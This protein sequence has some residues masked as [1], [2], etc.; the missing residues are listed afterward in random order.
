MMITY[1]SS[2]AMLM[3]WQTPPPV[4]NSPADTGPADE[5]EI[6]FRRQQH[7][8]RQRALDW[9]A[10]GGYAGQ[11]QRRAIK[12]MDYP[13]GAQK[14]K[15]KA[16]GRGGRAMGVGKGKGGKSAKGRRLGCL[17]HASSLSIVVKRSDSGN[18][19][20]GDC[21]PARCE[22]CNQGERFC[23]THPIPRHMG[24]EEGGKP[25]HFELGKR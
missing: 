11:Q 23:P 17:R 9:Q 14:G 18:Q 1:H 22:H 20:P 19:D 21:D 15:G 16:K 3:Q 6:H 13:D 4:S 10:A 2:A 12:G 25:P 24:R 7:H 5:I 8:G